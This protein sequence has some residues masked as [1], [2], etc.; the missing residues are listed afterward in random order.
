MYKDLLAT[1]K[2]SPIVGIDLG[3]T[4]SLVAACRDG[5]AYILTTSDGDSLLPSVLSLDDSGEV[6]VGD[7]ARRRRVTHPSTTINSIKRLMGKGGEL[8]RRIAQ[9]V[10]YPVLAED[11]GMAYVMLGDQK[12]SPPEISAKILQTVKAQAE[13]RLGEPVTRAVITVPAYFNDS[14]RQ[15]TRDAGRIAGL[16]VLRIVNEPTAA[17]LAYGLHKNKEGTIAVYDLGGGTF[18]VSILK[19]KDGIFEVLATNGDTHLG[20]DDLDR[21]LAEHLLRELDVD[22]PTPNL[23]AQALG[24]AEQAK[25]HLSEATEATIRIELPDGAGALEHTITR[26]R[27]NGLIDALVERTLVPCKNALADSDLSVKQIDEV[28]I[29]GGSTRVPLVREKVEAF[30]GMQPRAELNPDHV[31]AMGAAVQAQILAGEIKDMLLIDVTPLSMGIETFGGAFDRLVPRNTSIP[32]SASHTFTNAVEGQTKFLVH[33]LQGERELASDCRSLARFELTG[34][35]PKPAGM[36]RVVVTFLLDANGILQVKAHDEHS[37]KEAGIEVKPSYGLTDEQVE[38]MIQASY[39]H[40]EEDLN[41]RML[42]DRRNE[43]QTILQAIEKSLAVAGH[44]LD[45]SERETIDQA[46]ERLTRAMKGENVTAL[47]KAIEHADLTTRHLAEIQM[48]DAVRSVVVDR[49]LS[50]VEDEFAEGK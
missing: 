32:V 37:G 28:I 4:Y 15:A 8:A 20:G 18:D 12:L 25:R 48:T 30:F 43:A 9:E 23:M 41:T 42:V 33:V 7:A 45:A 36:S 27:F 35:D 31:V 14:E 17:A 19:L 1:Q 50:E 5:E 29:V 44:K 11:A 24:Q 13:A 21:A 49:A 22:T 3:T 40:A 38:G 39:D 47:N 6:L 46:T 16:E 34:V 2:D 10:A 26:D